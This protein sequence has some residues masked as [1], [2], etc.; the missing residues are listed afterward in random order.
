MSANEKSAI[1]LHV[2]QSL[3]YRATSSL[4]LEASLGGKSSRAY[5]YGRNDRAVSDQK[6]P[7]QC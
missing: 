2:F 1:I 4:L 7:I 6:S 3:G 5:L